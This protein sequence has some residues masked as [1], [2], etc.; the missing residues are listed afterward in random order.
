MGSAAILIGDADT[1]TAGLLAGDR[2]GV[3]HADLIALTS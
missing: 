2:G 1:T 3:V